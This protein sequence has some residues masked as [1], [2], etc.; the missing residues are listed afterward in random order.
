MNTTIRIVISCLIGSLASSCGLGL[1][2]KDSLSRA[3]YDS[4]MQTADFM[5]KAVGMTSSSKINQVRE[6]CTCNASVMWKYEQ[7]QGFS[8]ISNSAMGSELFLKCAT[9]E[10]KLIKQRELDEIKRKEKEKKKFIESID[11]LFR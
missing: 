4:C 10:E 2:P 7:K 3:S 8:M 11:S 1:P 5:Q 6:R 9:D